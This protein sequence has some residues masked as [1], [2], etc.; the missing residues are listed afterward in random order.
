M[1]TDDDVTTVVECARFCVGFVA[2]HLPVQVVVSD[3]KASLPEVVSL[4]AVRNVGGEAGGAYLGSFDLVACIHASRAQPWTRYDGV[5]MALDIKLTGASCVL[6]A[7]GPT[8]RAYMSHAR[9]VLKA[10]RKSN[11]R[12]G[13]CGVVAFL[14]RPLWP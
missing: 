6:G 9:E 14:L 7:N 5:E 10:A 11:A 12:V 1:L 4:L 3:A 2:G 13:S 8:M